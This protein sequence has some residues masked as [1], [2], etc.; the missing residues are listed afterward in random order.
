MQVALS[1][2]AQLHQGYVSTLER[3]RQI[4][5]LST[6]PAKFDFLSL[7]KIRDHEGSRREPVISDF[8]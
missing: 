1:T 5:S 8:G 3:S 7:S 6:A 4:P 2:K